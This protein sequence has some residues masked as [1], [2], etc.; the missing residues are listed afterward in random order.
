MSVRD[1]FRKGKMV[2]YSLKIKGQK[3]FWEKSPSQK[4][5]GGRGAKNAKEE[6]EGCE[7][8]RT[9]GPS[10]YKR[11][12]GGQIKKLKKKEKSELKGGEKERRWV[13]RSCNPTNGKKKE[14]MKGSSNGYNK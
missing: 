6:K 2:L 12:R 5:N 11:K 10:L 14:N 13:I 4:K 9:L 8:N 3:D 7:K 1:R